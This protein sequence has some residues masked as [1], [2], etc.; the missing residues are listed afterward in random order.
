MMKRSFLLLSCLPML[1]RAPGGEKETSETAGVTGTSSVTLSGAFAESRNLSTDPGVAYDPAKDEH[2]VPIEGI[3]GQTVYVSPESAEH[4][5]NKRQEQLEYLEHFN[6]SRS[7]GNYGNYG[8][9]LSI[10]DGEFSE[11]AATPPAAPALPDT[12]SATG[13]LHDIDKP[14]APQAD[15]LPA[16]PPAAPVS[17]G[18]LKPLAP[19]ETVTEP[20]VKTNKPAKP[21]K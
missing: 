19:E 4:I 21:G 8:R 2:L 14:A 1:M 18:S 15:P 10:P 7:V 6:R 5:L 16:T 17:E 20:L 3:N 13:A 9:S 12:S 11:S